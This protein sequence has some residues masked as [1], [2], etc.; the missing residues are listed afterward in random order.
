MTIAVCGEHS[1]DGVEQAVRDLLPD[2]GIPVVTRLKDP[3]E[4][5]LLEY[6]GVEIA[7]ATCL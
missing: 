3:F 5:G 4:A 7:I 2:N 6:E 1:A